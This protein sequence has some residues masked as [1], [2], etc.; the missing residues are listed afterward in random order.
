LRENNWS[1]IEDKKMM[2]KFIDFP[3]RNVIPAAP[4]ADRGILHILYISLATHTTMM[5]MES[6]RLSINNT[7]YIIYIITQSSIFIAISLHN[8]C[9][10]NLF[11]ASNT[12]FHEV[13]ENG[14][15]AAVQTMISQ[16]GMDIDVF[17]KFDRTPLHLAIRNGHIDICR[18]LIENGASIEVK[19][20]HGFSALYF[21]C[22]HGHVAIAEMLI[23]CGASLVESDLGGLTPLHIAAEKGHTDVVKLLLLKGADRGALD[24]IGYTPIDWACQKQH[25]ECVMLLRK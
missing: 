1:G 10:S 11:M 22:L 17:G 9:F 6:S 16:D 15:V 19:N 14:N 3:S 23:G 24:S 21:A 4:A 5:M 13:C 2:L 25:Q 12:K 18:L 8:H 20:A 7:I